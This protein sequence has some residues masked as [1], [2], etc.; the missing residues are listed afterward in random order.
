MKL[1]K[2]LA[3]GLGLVIS[4]V[5]L[6]F[7]FRNLNPAAV[8][9]EIQHVN[10]GWLLL[11]SAVYFVGVTLISI[12]WQFLLRSIKRISLGGLVPLVAIGYMGNN[13]YPFRSGEILRVVLLQR[14]YRAPMARVATTVLV[15][16]VFDGLVMLTFIMVALLFVNIQAVEIKGVASIAAPLFLTAVAVFFVLAARPNVMRRILHV[17]G[18]II[19]GRIHNLMTRLADEII[20]GL[21]ALRS[22]ADLAGAVV[23]SFASWMVEA[24]VYWMVSFAFG[25][26]VGYPVMLLTVG[27]VNLAGLIPASPGQIGVFE[28]FVSLVLIA[29]GVADTE[30]HAYALVVHVVIWLPVTLAGFAF[31]VRQG[32]G[33]GAITHAHELEQV[34][35]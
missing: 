23:S 3:V 24:S 8:W 19:P 31:L 15:E 17:M 9:A 32:L 22:P 1:N 10:V 16:R 27:V 21:Q 35:G 13:V 29:V 14:K 2:W 12:R 5:F 30:A 18:R 28:F 4:L 33:W 7:A 34:A 6:W 26:H 11:G 20:E 25:L